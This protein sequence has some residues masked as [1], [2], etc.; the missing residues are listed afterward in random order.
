MVNY[1]MLTIA[2]VV[3]VMLKRLQVM[4]RSGMGLLLGAHYIV[5]NSRAHGSG[6]FVREWIGTSCML[7]YS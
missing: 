5:L 6:A 7:N 1:C 2:K 3:L 4:H